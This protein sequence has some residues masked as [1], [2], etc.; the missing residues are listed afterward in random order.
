[1]AD[2]GVGGRVDSQQEVADQ[3]EQIHV[4]RRAQNFLDDFDEGQA[5][6]WRDGGEMLVSML[7]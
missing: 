7:L 4:R 3:S 1:M 6:F 2:V 5:D